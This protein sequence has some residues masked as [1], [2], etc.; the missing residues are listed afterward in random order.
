MAVTAKAYGQMP[1][2]ALKKL[3]SDLN[4]GGTTVRCMLCTS[5][6]VPDQDTHESKS[7][8]TNEI[9]GTGYTAGGV[10]LTTKSLAYAVRV[11]TF[12]A[13]D[14]EWTSATF[15]ARYAVLYDDTPAV[16]A[17]KKLLC[18]IDFGEDKSC[19]N[20][21]FRIQWDASGIF[22]VTVAA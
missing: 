12:N 1:L 6:Y 17:D 21:T 3:I 9:S 4:A 8:I 2:N 11:T 15:T 13:D 18:W 14:A 5:S 7:D 10:A 16:D 22:T 19:E 20:G